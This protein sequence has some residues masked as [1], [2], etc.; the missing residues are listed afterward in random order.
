MKS[1]NSEMLHS[2]MC[3]IIIIIIIII[4][5]TGMFLFYGE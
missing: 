1:Q 5:I 3:N 2:C 4:I